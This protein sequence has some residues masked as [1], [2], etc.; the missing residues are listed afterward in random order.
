MYFQLYLKT[1]AIYGKGL[2][3]ISL[4]KFGNLG[5]LE[6]QAASVRDEVELVKNGRFVPVGQLTE[7]ETNHGR[8]TIM[9]NHGTFSSISV[10]F[11][12]VAKNVLSF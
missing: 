12:I 3:G 8:I 5:H 1:K 10:L 4:W 7:T 6:P 11:T 9:G 2:P